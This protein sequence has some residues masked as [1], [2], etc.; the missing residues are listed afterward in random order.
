MAGNKP[1]TLNVILAGAFTFVTFLIFGLFLQSYLHQTADQIAIGFKT[2]NRN[3]LSA[4]DTLA[5]AVK[6]NS[7][8]ASPA[9]LC[10][11]GSYLKTQFFQ[12]ESGG[13][14]SGFLRENIFISPEDD[15]ADALEII[16]TVG[17]TGPILG[18]AGVFVFAQLLLSGLLIFS[19]WRRFRN[20]HQLE[21]N[22][23]SLARQAAHDIRSPLSALH[24][25]ANKLGPEAPKY[26]NLLIQVSKRITGIAELLL[27][28]SRNI[29][30]PVIKG[31]PQISKYENSLVNSISIQELFDLIEKLRL[32]KSIEN[33]N[34]IEILV[35]PYEF[36]G[37]HDPFSDTSNFVQS[38][39]SLFV[40]ANP[41]ELFRILSN[42]LNNSADAIVHDPRAIISFSLIP[43]KINIEP[44]GS[45][46]TPESSKALEH[47]THRYF[48]IQIQ[49]FGKGISPQHLAIFGKLQF[50]TKNSKGYGIG[51]LNMIQKIEEWG[52]KVA[53]ESV[54]D[55]GTDI[56]IFLR[57]E[58][59]R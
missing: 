35:H 24:A 46:K 21:M 44:S 4:K 59:K 10:A 31:E 57:V 50:S 12:R 22:F 34:K 5:L 19:Y 13:C 1:F 27:E 42:A 2:Q 6:L 18:A 11:K 16:L 55:Q 20:Q 43:S 3:E 14:N 33:R 8:M 51:T 40:I 41:D 49:D 48:V 23:A 39:H 30:R 47:Q 54:L 9:I 58:P 15:N 52:G 38:S 29:S 26:A 53:V 28:Q 37:A 36:V 7:L 25:L 17:L 56:K 32:E 45:R